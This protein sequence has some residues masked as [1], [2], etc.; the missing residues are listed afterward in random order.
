MVSLASFSHMVSLI[1]AAALAP[2]GWDDAIAEVHRGFAHTRNGI[3]Q[4]TSLAIADG[5]SRSMIGTLLP[6]AENTYGYYGRIDHVLQA[7]ERGTI[8]HVR[9]GDELIAPHTSTEFHTDWVRPNNIE[10]GL[11]AR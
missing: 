5:V 9:T 1:Y 2:A 4:S 3:V 8:G 7:V 6:T 11:F 10:H